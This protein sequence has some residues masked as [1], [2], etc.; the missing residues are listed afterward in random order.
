[1]TRLAGGHVPFNLPCYQA[2]CDVADARATVTLNGRSKESQ[3]THLGEDL[4][5]KL[6]RSGVKN[7]RVTC[8]VAGLRSVR[9]A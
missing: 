4:L 9:W 3:F 6:W 8:G 1:M 7:A 2:I 5:V